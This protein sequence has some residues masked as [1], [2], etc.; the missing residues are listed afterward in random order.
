MKFQGFVGPS[1]TLNSVNVDS[2]RCVNLYP[3]IIES[4]AGKEGQTAYLKSTPGLQKVITVGAGPIRCVHVDYAGRILVA[5][6]NVL[7]LVSYNGTT[8]TST[9]RGFFVTSTGPI[10]AA[11]SDTTTVLVDGTSNY[12]H[13]WDPGQLLD[14]LL[15]FNQLSYIGVA[16]ATWVVFLDGYFIF[17]KAGTNQFFVSG[18]NKLT[19][20]PLDFASAEGDP[21]KIIAFMTNYRDLWIFNEK[22]IEV[23]IRSSNPDFPF[24]RA[25][26][27]FIE[28]GCLAPNSVAKLE[29]FIVWLGR[30][31]F[32]QAMVYA[33]T[34]LN[35][36]RISTHAVEQAI[37]K[38]AN[39]KAAR[40]YTYQ[41]GG[42]LFY[43][44][45]FAE[46]TW[47]Y[48]G[49]TKM[50]HERAYTNAGNLER[51]R[52][53]VVA[54]SPDL[55]L[56]LV[57]DYANGNIYKFSDSY[58]T[59]DM[60]PITRL[61]SFPHVSSDRK[62]LFFHS[63]EIDMET[64]VGLN[65][66]VLGSDPQVMLQWSDDGGH[67]WSDETWTS[68]GGQVGGIGDFKKRVIWRRL[69]K[70]RDRVFR[71]AITDPVSVTLLGAELDIQPG[72]K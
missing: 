2:Q 55:D 29:G 50:W 7:Y 16:A 33:A 70:S 43:V 54:F 60:N 11:S 56:H 5:S 65:G 12:I 53:E 15:L 39:P 66:A 59:D 3:E 67:T 47:V 9:N 30:D 37:Q 36:Q 69:G 14:G 1:Y 45:N 8:W 26:S 13:N 34:G 38:Y 10:I 20:N 41:S 57:G 19:F 42:H 58:Y 52:G 21:D 4:G 40:A 31:S 35:P 23:F 49:S 22:T 17:N 32:G 18:Y 64:G 61:R 27:G 25:S 72:V 24:E 62:R 51:H 48:D 28:K 68:A 44:L 71:I 6:G 46:A 63:L